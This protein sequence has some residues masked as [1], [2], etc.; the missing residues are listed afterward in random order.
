M[1]MALAEVGQRSHTGPSAGVAPVQKGL[2]PPNV[3]RLHGSSCQT[4]RLSPPSADRSQGCRASKQARGVA[5]GLT[6]YS[7][8]ETF[9]F[10]ATGHSLSVG[11]PVYCVYL[12]AQQS[13]W[14]RPP[15]QPVGR[16]GS[17]ECAPLTSSAW[18]GRSML[19]FP[20][21]MS[22]T[23]RVLSLLPLTSSLLSADHATWYT[24]PTWPRR[25]V[26][27]LEGM[28]NKS[29][30][31]VYST[32]KWSSAAWQIYSAK[33]QPYFP[34][35]PS[36]ILIDLSNE[37]EA[38]SLVSGEKRTSLTSALCPVILA[39]GFLSSAGFHRNMVKSSEPD[40]KRSGAEPCGDNGGERGGAGD[41]ASCTPRTTYP[42][43]II[44]LQS[45]L[46][47]FFHC[48]WTK[49]SRESIPL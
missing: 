39:R 13:S 18:P 9:V 2:P 20:V 8:S 28:Q 30:W 36:Q 33:W 24:E 43:F 16:S 1:E 42:D 35:R 14:K 7:H 22:Q 19:S 48:K 29:E 25:D 15:F 27:Y 26:R 10:P 46:L 21:L 31:C 38:M 45:F 41:L 32:T 17:G 6:S 23:F 3:R 44:S 12:Y 49:W 4:G 47:H 34:V 37:A 40:T 5:A 11:T